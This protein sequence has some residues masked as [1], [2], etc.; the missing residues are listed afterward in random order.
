[1]VKLDDKSI[2]AINYV[3]ARGDRAEVVPIKDGVRVLRVKRETVKTD[4]K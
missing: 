2:S 4:K 3:I 1:M